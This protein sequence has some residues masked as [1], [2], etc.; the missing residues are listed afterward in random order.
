MGNY[1]FRQQKSV[2]IKKNFKK[3]TKYKITENFFTYIDKGG[4]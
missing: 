1:M 2:I 4:M 3:Q